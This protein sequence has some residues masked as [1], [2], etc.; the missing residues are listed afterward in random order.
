MADL[1]DLSVDQVVIIEGTITAL[2][3]NDHHFQ[4]VTI[5]LTNPETANLSGQEI[6]VSNLQV[7]IPEE[8]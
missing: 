3:S 2:D 7:T 6:K 4:E 1:V 8:G 5:K